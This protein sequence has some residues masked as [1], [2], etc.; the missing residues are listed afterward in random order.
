MLAVDLRSCAGGPLA[1][2]VEAARLFVQ[3]GMLAQFEARGTTR[4]FTTSGAADGAITMP[5]VLLVDNG[6]AGPAELLAAAITGNKR[7]E[8]VGER[9][10]GHA[11]L[12][13]LFP[14]PDGGALW[15]SYAQYFT[16][17]GDPIHE[18]GLQPEVAVTQP[19]PEFGASLPPGDPT[20]DRAIERLRARSGS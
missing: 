14:L 18:H 5:L 19:D 12:Q 7:G 6:T 16:V 13:R 3:S 20:M 4:A 9:T 2:G 8:L 10:A 17:P 15:M 1:A 11:A